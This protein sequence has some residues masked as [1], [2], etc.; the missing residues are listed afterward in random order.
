MSDRLHMGGTKHVPNER[1]WKSWHAMVDQPEH[2]RFLDGPLAGRQPDPRLPIV[3]AMEPLP[4]AQC[5]SDGDPI[6]FELL[7]FAT[8]ERWLWPSGRPFYRLQREVI[9]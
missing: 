4:P 9:S 1:R 3:M 7:A 2:V 5:T 6:N 8:Y